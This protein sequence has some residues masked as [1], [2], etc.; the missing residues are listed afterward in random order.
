MRPPEHE[1]PNGRHVIVDVALPDEE[2]VIT[3]AESVH[4]IGAEWTG[5]IGE[6]IACYLPENRYSSTD[7]SPFTQERGPTELHTSPCRTFYIGEIGLWSA[8]VAW[9]KDGI[10][11]FREDGANIIQAEDSKQLALAFGGDEPTS[12]DQHDGLTDTSDS[13]TAAINLLEGQEELA[14]DDIERIWRAVLDRRHQSSFRIALLEAYEGRCAITGADVPEALEAAHIIPF[15]EQHSFDVAE[16]LLLRGDIHTLFD[17]GLISVNPES[18]AVSI[19]PELRGTCYAE[20]EG[21]QISLPKNPSQHPKRESLWHRW[22]WYLGERH[23]D[24]PQANVA[25]KQE[26]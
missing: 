3:L 18:L 9:N 11:I 23:P 13:L 16:G 4:T 20:L 15:A 12:P 6:W 17:L 1:L 25:L 2:Q 22:N 5:H 8:F 19:S 14:Q 21:K 26:S 7:V 24:L 10:P